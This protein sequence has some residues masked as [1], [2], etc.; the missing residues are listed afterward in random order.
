MPTAVLA[1]RMLPTWSINR[2]CASVH[3]VVSWRRWVENCGLSRTSPRRCRREPVR[4][5]PGTRAGGHHHLINE[6]LAPQEVPNTVGHARMTENRRRRTTGRRQPQSPPTVTSCSTGRQSQFA[7][8][9][10]LAGTWDVRYTRL[11]R[12]RSGPRCS[13]PWIRRKMIG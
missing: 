9:G 7:E 10:T 8:P 1:T 3:C 13:A 6:D 11:L 12:S 5:H 2:T 4:G